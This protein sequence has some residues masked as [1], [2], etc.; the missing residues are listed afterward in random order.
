MEDF[1]Q[2]GDRFIVYNQIY[3]SVIVICILRRINERFGNQSINNQIMIWLTN[4]RALRI[5]SNDNPLV[6]N[7]ANETCLCS[8]RELAEVRF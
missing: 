3:S 4:L 2:D 1:Y 7:H 6:G 8:L 5:S